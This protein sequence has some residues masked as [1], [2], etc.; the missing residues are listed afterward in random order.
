M[1]QSVFKQLDKST[2]RVLR[3]NDVSS[4][5]FAQL[6]FTKIAVMGAMLPSRFLVLFICITLF[7]HASC[8]LTFRGSARLVRSHRN[9]AVRSHSTNGV[10]GNVPFTL[11]RAGTSRAEPYF[12][13]HFIE[14]NSKTLRMLQD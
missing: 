8:F 7:L 11:R 10:A 6:R 1:L 2:V 9:L 14:E 5:N 12:T 3:L 13:G 4:A